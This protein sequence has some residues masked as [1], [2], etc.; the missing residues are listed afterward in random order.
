VYDDGI[1][2]EGGD[3]DNADRLLD[4]ALRTLR[5]GIKL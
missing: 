2:V 1:D 3:T 4:A 5:P